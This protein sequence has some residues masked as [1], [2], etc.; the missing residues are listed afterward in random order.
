MALQGLR[1]DNRVSRTGKQGA[2]EH[3]TVFPYFHWG[4]RNH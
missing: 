3:K 4:G 2:P 1:K